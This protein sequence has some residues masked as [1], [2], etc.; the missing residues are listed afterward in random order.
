MF[1]IFLGKIE[2]MFRVFIIVT[3][4]TSKLKKRSEMGMDKNLFLSWMCKT[5]IK[6]KRASGGCLG[7]ERR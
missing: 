3:F 2:I 7:T 5:E 4:L 1:F 6:R